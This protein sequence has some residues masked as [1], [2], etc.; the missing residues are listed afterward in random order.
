MRREEICRVTWGDLD[1]QTKTLTIRDRKDPR[2]FLFCR[3]HAK[4]KWCR[5]KLLP[6]NRASERGA[7]IRQDAIHAAGSQT[8]F[9]KEV[10]KL[11]LFL[12]LDIGY[13]VVPQNSVQ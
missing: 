10:A 13:A 1:P 8:L 9:R 7:A 4:D 2:A 3:R 6:L 5:I 11:L 12:R